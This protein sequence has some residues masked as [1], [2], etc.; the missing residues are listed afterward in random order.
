MSA[1]AR[2]AHAP[3][4]AP[5]VQGGHSWGSRRAASPRAGRLGVGGRGA[6]P[7]PGRPPLPRPPPGRVAPRLIEADQVDW[8]TAT[9]PE[10]R[11]AFATASTTA[12][13]AARAARRAPRTLA[14]VSLAVSLN[15]PLASIR[16]RAAMSID[17][18]RRRGV[19]LDG[20][21][22]PPR[23]LARQ[24]VSGG[25]VALDESERASRRARVRQRHRYRR[26]RGRS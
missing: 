1:V 7:P 8:S 13:H 21:L 20:G 6:R 17:G 25:C 11:R 15:V 14:A 9:T 4:R 18:C 19:C 24:P 12:N 3:D 16:P 10:T 2:V 23:S 5:S 26:R 22:M